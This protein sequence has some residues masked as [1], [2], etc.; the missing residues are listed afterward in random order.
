MDIEVKRALL[1]DVA[2]IA[3]LF[4]AYR[5]FYNRPNDL[6]ACRR[7]LQARL[8]K[9]ESVIFMVEM[10]G[11]A[12]GFCQL[13]PAW[14]SV[15]MAPIYVLYDLFVDADARKHGIASKLLDAAAQFGRKNGAVRLD[16]S[17]ARTNLT[18]QS[19]YERNG[20]VRDD[21]FLTYSLML[22]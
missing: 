2:Q 5:Q 8:S 12:V 22:G 18:A 17:T 6:E 1:D 10:D 7:Y 11:Q 16:L 20:W 9:G 4:D 3:G 14:C 19:L 21:V 15:E 13:Y